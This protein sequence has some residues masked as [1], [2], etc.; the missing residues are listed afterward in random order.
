MVYHHISCAVLLDNIQLRRTPSSSTQHSKMTAMLRLMGVLLCSIFAA[1]DVMPMADF[2][3]QKVRLRA[4]Q[5][6]LYAHSYPVDLFALRTEPSLMERL[7]L[8]AF[9]DME[10]YKSQHAL[11]MVQIRFQCMAYVSKNLTCN[12]LLFGFLCRWPVNGT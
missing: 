6:A 7:R 1:A 12:F 10:T 4:D 8:C 3:L 5:S 9:Q 11:F 2:D